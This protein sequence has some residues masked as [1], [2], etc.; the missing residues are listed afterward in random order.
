MWLRDHSDTLTSEIP[1]CLALKKVNLQNGPSTTYHEARPR[2]SSDNQKNMLKASQ[3]TS[4]ELVFKWKF[5][6]PKI[7]VFKQDSSILPTV[8]PSLSSI[9]CLN[10]MKLEFAAMLQPSVKW[11]YPKS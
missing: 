2:P 4:W 7:N 11:S 8:P 1:S 5:S 6:L 9:S 3:L 10:S